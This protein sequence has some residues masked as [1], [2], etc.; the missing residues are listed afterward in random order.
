MESSRTPET[1]HY[2]PGGVKNLAS[3]L[4]PI[5]ELIPPPGIEN[6]MTTYID[7]SGMPYDPMTGGAPINWS[8]FKPTAEQ[9]SAIINPQIQSAPIPTAT[10]TAAPKPAP[11]PAPKQQPS[12]DFMQYYQGWNPEAARQDFQS[13][14]GGDI[15][16]LQQARGAGGGGGQDNEIMR[17]IEELYNI[18][19]NALNELYQNIQTVELPTALSGLDVQKNQ[20][21]RQLATAGEEAGQ[22]FTTQEQEAQEYKRSALGEARDAFNALSQ[23]ISARYGAGASTGLAMTEIAQQ[24]F[25][26]TM[27]DVNQKWNKTMTTIF[28]ERG[29]I[30]KYLKDK[31]LEIEENFQQKVKEVNSEFISRLH[32]INA[33]KAMNEQA[34]RA[35]QIDVLQQAQARAQQWEDSVKLARLNL[36]IYKQQVEIEADAAVEW[37]NNAVTNAFADTD[38]SATKSGIQNISPIQSLDYTANA[39]R[40]APYA[41][42]KQEDKFKGLT[43]PFA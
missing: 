7:A 20:L 27:G 16:R 33:Q 28:T 34:K 42:A 13:A 8:N 38:Y 10:P 22:E 43:N 41:L 14:F 35:A 40:Y 1:F 23:G 3:Y 5:I 25:F 30:F 11:Q 31:E 24:A 37:T 29:R 39:N 18:S 2:P 9:A 19:A 6:N 4:L 32:E 17:R 21:A 36:E 15:G 12:G 26:K